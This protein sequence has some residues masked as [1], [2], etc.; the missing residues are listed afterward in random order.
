M[1][2]ILIIFTSTIL[3]SSIHFSN[4][5]VADDKPKIE[6]EQ[7]GRFTLHIVNKGEQHILYRI[8]TATGIVSVFDPTSKIPMMDS[9]W[10]QLGSK[11]ESMKEWAKEVG[12]EGKMIFKSPYWQKL[13]EKLD[14]ITVLGK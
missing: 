2:T 9:D 6:K 3:L 8:D 1:K 5:V 12:K 13:P 11:A 14:G 7:V 4:H 10:E